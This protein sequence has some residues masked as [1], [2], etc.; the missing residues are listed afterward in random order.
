MKRNT[1][2]WAALL[3]ALILCLFFICNRRYH[4]HYITTN[5]GIKNTG[6]PLE[7]TINLTSDTVTPAVAGTYLSN[8][9]NIIKIN[10][11]GTNSPI[12][13]MGMVLT[14]SNITILYNQAF[15]LLKTAKTASPGDYIT[16]LQITY[17][18]NT[19]TTPY[20]MSYYFLPLCLQTQ[21]I[22]TVPASYTYICIAAD[23]PTSPGGTNSYYL[24]NSDGAAAPDA[25]GRNVTDA[26]NYQNFI[27]I[28]HHT[29]DAGVTGFVNT[30]PTDPTGDVVS[31]VF[32]FQEIEQ[33]MND[34]PGCGGLNIFNIA[35]S[36]TISG[37]VYNKQELLLG[38]IGLASGANVN[39]VV[40]AVTSFKNEFADLSHMCPPDDNNFTF[41]V[42]NL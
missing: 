10:T 9:G 25:N 26:A 11:N 3:L 21:N 8:V 2:Q 34:N 40:T 4:L 5:P 15:Q 24:I 22:T 27:M 6:L 36:V 20:T 28:Q 16:A 41:S 12:N 19:S 35:K 31:V 1:T 13:P 37:Q 17:G 18:I 39:G 23:N 32:P 14:Q 33:L 29:V 30:S 42:I 7:D 38:P